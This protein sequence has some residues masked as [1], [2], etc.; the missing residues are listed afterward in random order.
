[1]AQDKMVTITT[2]TGFPPNCFNQAGAII[3]L[4]EIL[5]PGTDSV[6]LQGLSWDVVR[7]SYHKQGFTIRLFV[8]PWSRAM[9]YV[10]T[11]KVQLIFPALK[12]KRREKIYLF[13]QE[14]VDQTS[15]RIYIKKE[16][17]YQWDNFKWLTGKRIAAVR[18]WSYGD[19]WDEMKGVI[20]DPTSSIMQGFYML[21]IGRV[22]GVIGY[23]D[24]FDY[25]LKQES[26]DHKYKKSPVLE[27]VADYLMGK[28]I[29][30][31]QNLI[32]EFD[33]GKRL[34]IK[35]GLMKKIFEKWTPYGI[36]KSN[37]SARIGDEL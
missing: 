8:V 15:I 17:D 25:K 16:N 4:E 37:D 30:K 12:T 9:H 7:E 33:T 13:S 20:K 2:L 24:S 19:N 1:M 23:E 36:V 31:T 5:P 32:N 10:E 26:V 35:N 3:K 28:K 18:E 11:G 22:F 21:D 34:L 6:Q 27:A 29:E 14:P